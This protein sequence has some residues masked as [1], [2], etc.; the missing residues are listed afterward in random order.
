MA[1]DGHVD[2]CPAREVT[3]KEKFQDAASN[4]IK[5]DDEGIDKIDKGDSCYG[6]Y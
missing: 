4:D 1:D 6:C 2:G 3:T 5:D